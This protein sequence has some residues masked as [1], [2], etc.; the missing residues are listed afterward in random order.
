MLDLADKMHEDF[1]RAISATHIGHTGISEANYKA[2][3][4]PG[5]YQE[6]RNTMASI[7][8]AG[9]GEFIALTEDKALIRQIVIL[10][11]GVRWQEEMTKFLR[12]L[13]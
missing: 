4:L 9:G 7:A 3:P 10:T 11:F 8:Y 13:E 6:F 5:F 1:E 2:T 12:D